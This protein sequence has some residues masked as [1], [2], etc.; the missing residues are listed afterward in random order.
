MII[1]HRSL[2]CS[3][4]QGIVRLQSS[5]AT[6]ISTED[7]GENGNGDCVP[8]VFPFS[9]ETPEGT[10]AGVISKGYITLGRLRERAAATEKDKTIISR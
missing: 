5:T 10:I 7:E 4:D 9:K 8:S 6:E 1:S 2:Q 3:I